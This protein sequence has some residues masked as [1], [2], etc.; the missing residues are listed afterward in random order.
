M[1][2]SIARFLRSN[3]SLVLA[4]GLLGLSP[5]S[6]VHAQ[7]LRMQASLPFQ[8][9]VGDKALAGGNY[10][11]EVDEQSHRIVFHN[12]T[13]YAAV[14]VG[15][16]SAN[17]NEGDA[18]NGRLQFADYGDTHVLRKIWLSGESKGYPIAESKAEREAA[19]RAARKPLLTEVAA[20]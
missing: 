4:C 16:P 10:I 9:Q 14:A 1:K 12:A 20:R 3:K 19:R 18:S 11:V 13:E 2:H 8:F 17:R 7:S 5:V 15:L 6:L